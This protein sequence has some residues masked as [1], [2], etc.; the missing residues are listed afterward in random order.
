LTAIKYRHSARR[1][2]AVELLRST[3]LEGPWD[4]E[5]LAAVA[6]RAIEIEEENEDL[7]ALGKSF[8]SISVSAPV[9][10]GVEW[11]PKLRMASP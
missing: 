1:R 6:S 5:L 8:R 11:M 3:G 4:G 9:F 7:R 2:Q 10:T